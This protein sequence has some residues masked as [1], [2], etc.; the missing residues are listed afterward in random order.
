MYL[1]VALVE[2]GSVK[3]RT[4]RLNRVL[5]FSVTTLVPQMKVSSPSAGPAM[6]SPAEERKASEP[7]SV[8]QRLSDFKRL[9]LCHNLNTDR[10]RQP[11]SV[12]NCNTT[13]SFVDFNTSLLMCMWTRC[14][15]QRI[16]PIAGS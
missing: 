4:K 8:C 10:R 7:C 6:S 16:S 3:L 5:T 13:G 14:V 9:L 1:G 11:L 2:A 15:F 12:Q